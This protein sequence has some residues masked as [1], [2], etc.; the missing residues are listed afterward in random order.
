MNLR[1]NRHNLHRDRTI[2]PCLRAGRTLV[3]FLMAG[4]SLLIARTG[5]SASLTHNSANPDR[6]V[7]SCH[8]VEHAMGRSCVPHRVRRLVVLDTGE[9]DISVGLG[10][11]P[12]ATTYPYQINHLPDYIPADQTPISVGLNSEPDLERILQLQPDLILGS[13]SVHG[14]LYPILSRI[15]PTVLSER[16][17]VSWRDN[18]QLFARALQ[19]EQKASDWLTG[20]EQQCQ[21]INAL[22]RQKGRPTVSVVRSMQD[23]VRLYLQDTFIHTLLAQCGIRRPEN[24]DIKGF[25]T[26]LRSPAQIRQLEGELILL[27]EYS[28]ELGS[29]IRQWQ[30]TGFWSLL[31]GRIVPVDDHY[32]MLGIGPL[33]AE[34][35]LHDLEAIIRAYTPSS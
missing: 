19:Q 31:K 5:F 23:H 8:W 32:W 10:H 34:Q 15:A 6:S 11:L 26:R 24:Q 4:L 12:V 16:I 17:G 20:F 3:L 25:A 28:P 22:Y 2:T 35:V 18:L 7:E 14:H 13:R 27:S 1:Y 21:R 30:G 9:L 33:A 29:M